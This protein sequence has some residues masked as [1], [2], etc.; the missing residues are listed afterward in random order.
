MTDLIG[1]LTNVVWSFYSPVI[2]NVLVTDHLN[3]FIAFY[4]TYGQP[5]RRLS[6]LVVPYMAPGPSVQFFLIDGSFFVIWSAR[7]MGP[8]MEPSDECLLVSDHFFLISSP[9]GMGPSLNIYTRPR[10]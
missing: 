8:Y 10:T 3:I 2:I 1:Q 9:H 5:E 4:E 6:P 7:G